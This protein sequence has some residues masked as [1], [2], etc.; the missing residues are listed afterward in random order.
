M[1]T[2]LQELSPT[3]D[4]NLTRSLMNIHE[5][6]LDEF[7]DE[8]KFKQLALSDQQKEAWIMVSHRNTPTHMCLQSN[9]GRHRAISQ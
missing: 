1:Y 3:S 7:K 9:N 5:C 8:Q 2:A 4:A 6:L